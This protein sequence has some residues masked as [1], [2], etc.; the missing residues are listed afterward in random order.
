MGHLRANDLILHFSKDQRNERIFLLPRRNRQ[1][2]LASRLSNTKVGSIKNWKGGQDNGVHKWMP[3]SRRAPYALHHGVWKKHILDFD[4]MRA[5]STHS[6]RAPRFENLHSL[7]LQRQREVVNRRSFAGIVIDA[8][9]HQ[10]V[11]RRDTT[12]ENLAP[13]ESKPALDLF[14]LAGSRQ[15]VRSSA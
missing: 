10:D 15:P 14:E 4:I 6:E 7:T 1:R 8:G 2:D 5:R 13:G 12:A 9:R 11:A 3:L